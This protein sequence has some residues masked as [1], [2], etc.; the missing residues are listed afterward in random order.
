MELIESIFNFL[1]LGIVALGGILALFG[2]VQLGRG[3]YE[4]NPGPMNQG[5]WMIGG[6]AIIMAAGIVLVPMV[7]QYFTAIGG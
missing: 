2:L 3:M 5:G 7:G 6:G 4:N 1:S